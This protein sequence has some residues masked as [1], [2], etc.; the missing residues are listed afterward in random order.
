MTGRGCQK[1]EQSS[2]AGQA[3]PRNATNV[4]KSRTEADDKKHQGQAR[5]GQGFG[6]FSATAMATEE[7]SAGR[8]IVH[9]GLARTVSGF[10]VSLRVMLWY[11]LPRACPWAPSL[12][13]ASSQATF[14]QAGNTSLSLHREPPGLRV[15]W[16]SLRL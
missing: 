13:P 6:P 1:T 4:K 15:W 14:Q 3:R 9:T 7:R 10:G 11:A 8:L 5:P 2:Q 16:Q 12:R